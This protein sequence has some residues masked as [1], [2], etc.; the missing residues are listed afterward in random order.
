LERSLPLTP[1]PIHT[2]ADLNGVPPTSFSRKEPLRHPQDLKNDAVIGAALEHVDIL[3]MNQDELA[4]LTGCRLKGTNEAEREDGFA[5]ANAV[6]L[7]LRCGVAVVVVTR[8]KFGSYVACNSE[9]R[10][11]RCPM[12]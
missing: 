1:F 4:L 3:H 11:R 6:N 9:E 12:L 2:V 8:G 7:F 10:F 5:I